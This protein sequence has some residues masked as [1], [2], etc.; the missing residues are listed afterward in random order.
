MRI[1]QP[2]AIAF[3][4]R[5]ILELRADRILLGDLDRDVR[6]RHFVHDGQQAQSDQQQHVKHR[7][8]Q[9]GRRIAQDLLKIVNFLLIIVVVGLGNLGGRAGLERDRAVR[10]RKRLRVTRR[11]V[12]R[13]G[14][15]SASWLA[16][17]RRQS[18]FGLKI[19]VQGA[20][21]LTP[22][23]VRR[24]GWHEGGRK[25]PKKGRNASAPIVIAPTLKSNS[26]L[27][28]RQASPLAA[29]RPY[30]PASGNRAAHLAIIATN[31]PVTA[32]GRKCRRARTARCMR[33]TRRARDASLQ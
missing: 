20:H 14:T 17:Q 12:R 22:G 1:F 11:G 9:P 23:Q 26:A 29:G 10:G 24:F 19:R 33:D 31:R 6:G 32:R 15:R 16:G 28:L 8:D 2:R 3:Q 25:C 30:A 13:R 27:S 5:R 7:A 18:A 4:N 21:S